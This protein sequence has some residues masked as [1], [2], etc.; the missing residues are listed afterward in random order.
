MNIGIKEEVREALEDVSFSVRARVAMQLGRESISSSIVAISELVK[1]AYD[2]DA[3]NVWLRFSDL[4][5][6]AA[7]LIIEDDGQGMSLGQLRNH[8]LVIG[9]DNKATAKKSKRKTRTLVGEKGLGR[10]GL[11]RLAHVTRLQTF[12]QDTESSDTEIAEYSQIQND[13]FDH[14]KYGV[15]L[16]IEWS[17]Y[18]VQS[19][20][21][22]ETIKHKLYAIPKAKPK[23]T[24]L[25]LEELKDEWSLD[26]LKSLY[27]DLSLLVSPFSGINDFA[28]WLDTGLGLEIDGRVGSGRFLESAEWKLTALLAQ[29]IKGWVVTY[30]I[31]SP[32]GETVSIP[33]LWPKA[34]PPQCGPL[35]F[36]LYFYSRGDVKKTDSDVSIKR[37]DIIGFLDAN[38]GIR[39]YRDNFRVKPYGDPEAAGEGDWLGLNM[40]R[41]KHPSGVVQEGRWRVAYNQVVGAVFIERET[42][43]K[44][45]DQTNREGLVEGPGLTDL[46]I[47]ALNTVDFFEKRRQEY[48]RSRKRQDEF[49]AASKDAAESSENALGAVDQATKTINDILELMETSPEDKNLADVQPAL[50]ALVQSLTETKQAVASTNKA[51]VDMVRAYEERQQEYEQKEN[52]LG[53]LASLGILTAVFGHETLSHTNLVL[54]NF[55]LLKQAMVPILEAVSVET[56]NGIPGYLEDIDYGVQRINTF[57]KFTIGNVRRDKRQRRQVNIDKIARKVIDAFELP[58]REI[59]IE[60]EV[61]GK[62]PQIGAFL[63]DW[64]SIFIN[65]L[66]NA[67]WALDGTSGDRR[68]IR[69]RFWTQDKNIHISF[70]DGGRGIEPGTIDRIFEPTFSTRRNVRGDVVGTGMG[71]SILQNLIDSYRGTIH[72]EAAC[73]IGG[74]Q[75]HIVIPIDQKA[76]NKKR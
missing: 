17:K 35:R 29:S 55:G 67:V 7:K 24:V 48:E 25:I 12:S 33:Q 14:K 11:D 51:Q 27:N 26:S 21:R 10:L 63:I 57:A 59:M 31:T 70:A 5:T 13:A 9:T 42:N 46:R 2:A 73:D 47:F 28:I 45:S 6:N 76:E 18:E 44:L 75:F 22:L 16:E 15:E 20:A 39:I 74:A 68:K 8:W 54:N 69:V 3:D 19:D 58:I 41:V 66:T 60:F 61:I 52:T 30:D 49:E 65:L 64:E 4:G 23:G 37:A 1:N 34:S 36:D 56:A 72:V 38:Q 71:L 50:A 32:E 62:I 43:A 40:R 53:N